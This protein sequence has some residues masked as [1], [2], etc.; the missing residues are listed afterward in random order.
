MQEAI[1]ATQGLNPIEH[2]VV[3]VFQGEKVD[4]DKE[5]FEVCYF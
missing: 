3:P 4:G 2:D 1:N 5:F